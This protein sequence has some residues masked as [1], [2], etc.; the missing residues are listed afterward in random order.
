MCDK[1]DIIEGNIRSVKLSSPDYVRWDP[2][3]AVAD[4][5]KRIKQQEAQYQ[6]VSPDEGPFIKIMN[7]G[8]KIVVNRIEGESMGRGL[9]EVVLMM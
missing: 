1:D 3:K 4:Y 8:E 7:V 6:E 5:W 9:G 2:E